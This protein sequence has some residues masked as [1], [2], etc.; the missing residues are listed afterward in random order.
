MYAY[1]KL[2]LDISK[3]TKAMFKPFAELY[4]VF[5]GF[6][7]A[8]LNAWRNWSY[9]FRMKCIHLFRFA[10]EAIV[11]YALYWNVNSVEKQ[12]LL[13]FKWNVLWYLLVLWNAVYCIDEA[14]NFDL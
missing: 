2:S 1:F 8:R 3:Q 14:N 7:F 4:V 10:A 12:A 6:L 13:E 11:A 9:P 5:T